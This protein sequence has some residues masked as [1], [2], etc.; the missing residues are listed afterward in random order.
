MSD[1]EIAKLFFQN[2][3]KKLPPHE[4]EIA[5]AVYD[6]IWCK[7]IL[8]SGK[9]CGAPEIKNSLCSEHLR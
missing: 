3:L 4:A 5:R 9:R 7:H 8:P 1:V 2:L 6:T